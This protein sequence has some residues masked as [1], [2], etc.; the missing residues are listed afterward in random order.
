[1]EDVII[2][3]IKEDE[4]DIVSK[5]IYELLPKTFE[6]LNNKDKKNLSLDFLENCLVAIKDDKIIGFSCIFNQHIFMLENKKGT[7][8]LVY[9]LDKYRRKKIGTSLMYKLFL[10]AYINDKSFPYSILSVNDEVIPFFHKL[11]FSNNLVPYGDEKSILGYKCC[12]S[13][14]LDVFF[15]RQVDCYSL[16]RK[17]YKMIYGDAPYIYTD[18]EV[19]GFIYQLLCRK[20]ISEGRLRFGKYDGEIDENVNLTN[21]NDDKIREEL[22]RRKVENARR[23]IEKANQLQGSNLMDYSYDDLL[24][25]REETMRKREENKKHSDICADGGKG[26]KKTKTEIKLD[27]DKRNEKLIAEALEGMVY[28]NMVQELIKN[29]QRLNKITEKELRERSGLSRQMFSKIKLDQ[30]KPKKKTLLALCIALCLS[31]EQAC[32]LLQAGGYAFDDSDFIDRLIYVCLLDNNDSVN[33]VRYI[34]EVNYMLVDQG[35]DDFLFPDH[36]DFDARKK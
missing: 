2:R 28:K 11:G 7:N 29:Y 13:M 10:Y 4:R 12:I 3:N 32:L 14:N 27:E 20:V 1:M 15:K 8:F 6:D 34:R 16:E 17:R 36:M 9:V 19:D 18:E 33:R 21:S 25:V 30:T 31:K 22:L 24:R 35:Y 26:R 5:S 23:I